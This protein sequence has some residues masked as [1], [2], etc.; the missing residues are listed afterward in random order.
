MGICQKRDEEVRKTVAQARDIEAAK[1]AAC[2]G[3]EA[4]K[5][6][7]IKL[8]KKKRLFP[9]SDF[10]I[11]PNADGNGDI[12]RLSED[13]DH[14]FALYESIGMPDKGVRPHNHITTHSHIHTT[15]A[16]IAGF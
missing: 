3:A 12:Y 1:G 15:W 5:P 11:D 7:L 2:E 9:L 4:V 13:D 16:V 14:Q 6:V 8:A 10:P